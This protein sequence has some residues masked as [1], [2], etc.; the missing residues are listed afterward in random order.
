[1]T[2]YRD[3]VSSRIASANNLALDDV[4]YQIIALLRTDGRMPYRSLAKELGLTEA[5][6]RAR[7]KRLEESETMRV[8]AVTDIEAAGFGMLLAVGVQVEGRPALDVST[9]LAKVE[10]VYSVSQVVGSHDI[11][12]LSIAQD[13]QAVDAMLRQLAEVKGVRKIMP[14]MAVDV[15]KN[16]PNWVPFE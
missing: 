14:S 13:Q 15:L 10:G 4:D 5:T 7:V 9:D 11:E 16:Q 12:V 3:A 8:V 6:V 1:M 2:D